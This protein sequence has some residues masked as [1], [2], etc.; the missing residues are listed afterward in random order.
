MAPFDR[1]HTSSYSYSIVTL[2]VSCSIFE[3]KRGIGRKTPIFTP[4]YFNLHDPL[5]ALRI[6][7]KILIQTVRVPELLGGAKYCREDNVSA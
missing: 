2:A 5:E 6:F 7:T 3:T 4:L 1:S